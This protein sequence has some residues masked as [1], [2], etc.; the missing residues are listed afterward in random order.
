MG[1]T[2]HVCHKIIG[3]SWRQMVLLDAELKR[4]LKKFKQK[5]A[6]PKAVICSV[7]HKDYMPSF[8]QS[9]STALSVSAANYSE[10]NIFLKGAW[11]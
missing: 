1:S 7:N 3:N 6:L 10:A 9:N 2:P 8:D 11:Q 4:F 5:K